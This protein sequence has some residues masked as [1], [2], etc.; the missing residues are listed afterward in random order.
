MRTFLAKITPVLYGIAAGAACFLFVLFLLFTPM[1]DAATEN[2]SE[3][4]SHYITIY[5][6]GEKL[7]SVKTNAVT[8]KEALERADITL[9]AADSV[10]PAL[11]TII[12]TENY[13][14]NIHRARPVVVIDGAVKKYI[15]SSCYDADS[16]AE[17][18]GITIYDGDK[19]E[20]LNPS[21]EFLETGASLVLKVT[22]N[23][24]HTVT[25][26]EPIAFTEETTPDYNLANG[27][28]EVSQVGED[29]EKTLTYQVEF[30][31]GVEVSRT[32]VSEEITKQPVTKITKVGAKAS[33]SPGQETCASWVRA[34]GVSE[35]DLSNALTLIYHESGCRVDAQNK[36]SSAYGIPQALPG[37]KMASAGADWQTNPVT[38]IKWMDGYV[39]KRY[40][41]W[42]Q[43][44]SYW[45][46]H[47][48]Y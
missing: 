3:S 23:G 2:E 32:L 13:Y 34:A 35:A 9:D 43:A 39:K 16:I 27:T 44:M 8:V 37:S 36:S 6:D 46:A 14:I 10:D 19:V 28:S 11:D 17:S 18:A 45:W 30:K 33:V 4:N 24:G 1:A 38:Q 26:K 29:G 42:A 7:P 25:V 20:T 21:G 41:G 15:L 22:H 12:N 47:G 31:D 5:D 40:G 48:N